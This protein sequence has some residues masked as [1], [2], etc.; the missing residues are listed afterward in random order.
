[1]ELNAND[2]FWHTDELH[3]AKLLAVKRTVASGSSWPEA[4]AYELW[5]TWHIANSHLHVILHLFPEGIGSA[6]MLD[7][8]GCNKRAKMTTFSIDLSSLL[9]IFNIN[10]MALN[11]SY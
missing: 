1:V 4:A 6:T 10:N 11:D 2:S 5:H 3:V 9:A 8:N 7:M